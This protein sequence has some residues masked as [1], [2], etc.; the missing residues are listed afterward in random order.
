MALQSVRVGDSQPFT[1]KV[2][3]RDEALVSI[4]LEEAKDLR[5]QADPF[6][7]E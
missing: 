4:V 2:F 1:F 7:K 5:S 3:P 6:N